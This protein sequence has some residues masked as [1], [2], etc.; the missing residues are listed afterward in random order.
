M[1]DVLH[2][3][4]HDDKGAKVCLSMLS[5][6]VKCW[7]FCIVLHMMIMGVRCVSLCCLVLSNVGCVAW[8]CTW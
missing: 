1:L 3:F 6:V 4:S 2:C 7:M 8:F 5:G